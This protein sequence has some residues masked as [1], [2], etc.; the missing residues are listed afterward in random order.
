M[1]SCLPFEPFGE[2]DRCEERNRR[3]V[4]FWFQHQKWTAVYRYTRIELRDCRSIFPD[5]PFVL[6]PAI[7]YPDGS[8]RRYGGR[9]FDSSMS[10]A[11]FVERSF[12]M[13]TNLA[14]RDRIDNEISLNPPVVVRTY[15][16]R[17]L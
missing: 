15:K 8:R 14:L 1:P 9:R 13:L 6:E 2:P 11:D 4:K 10:E 16:V 3:F 12:E 17:T 7:F 5:E